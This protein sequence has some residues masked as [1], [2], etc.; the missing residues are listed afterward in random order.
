MRRALALVGLLLVGGCAVGGNDS[1]DEV[2]ITP[3]AI[4]AVALQYLPVTPT[5]A[6]DANLPGRVG[7]TLVLAEGERPESLQLTIGDMDEERAGFLIA[8]CLRTCD[9][10]EVS[11]TTTILISR[12]DRLREATTELGRV[13][14]VNIQVLRPGETV[15]AEY[16]GRPL[17]VSGQAE[18]GRL[19]VETLVRMVQDPSLGRITVRGMVEQG[20]ELPLWTDERPTGAPAS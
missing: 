2:D 5:S 15:I 6:Y 12:G 4:A 10:Q 16:E 18:R 19:D 3:R 1:G 17:R 9:I 11:D 8:A 20:A 7:A 14:F 13:D